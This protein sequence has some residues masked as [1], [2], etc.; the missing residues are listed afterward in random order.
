MAR[1]YKLAFT[2]P[3]SEAARVRKA[4]G[5]AGAGESLKYAYASFSLR[6]TG[7][8]L[9]KEGATPAIGTV[10]TMEEV[11]EEKVEC[12]VEESR[13]DAVLAALRASHPYEEIAF[14]LFPLDE[15]CI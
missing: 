11:E 10:G 13:V 8:F 9:P 2:V 14:D 12:Q 3:V 1:L 7:R 5:D 6:G 4:V 15:R